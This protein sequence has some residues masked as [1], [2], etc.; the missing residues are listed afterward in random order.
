MTDTTDALDVQLR[1]LIPINGL[2]QHHQSEIISQSEIVAVKK[3]RFL[4]NRG[5]SDPYSFYVIDGQI[6][7]SVDGSRVKAVEGGTDGAKMAL[8]QLQPRQMS[9]KALTSVR[10]L[11]MDRGLLDRVLMLEESAIQGEMEVADI[12]GEESVDWMTRMLQSELFAR[13]PAANIQG[14][15]SRM[16]EIEAKQGEVIVK[17]GTPGDYYYVVQRGRCA[18]TRR[19]SSNANEI[20]LAE[21]AEGD[22]FGEE[23]LV[24][25]AK[26]NANV[27][28][29]TDGVLMRLTKE[30][31]VQLIKTPAL[32]TVT[33]DEALVRV[34]SGA[35]W[36]DVRFPDELG[37]LCVPGAMNIPLNVL[38]IQ[39]G[40]LDVAVNY[41]AVCDSGVRSSSAAFLLTGL[42]FDVAYL[43]GGLNGTPMA[44][45]PM[46]QA[47]TQPKRTPSAAP[48]SAPATT[49]QVTVPPSSGAGPA[50]ST[51][52]CVAPAAVKDATSPKAAA[53]ESRATTPKTPV[54]ASERVVSVAPER[55]PNPAHELVDAEVRASALSTELEKAK[56][57]LEAALQ[58]RAEAEA[59]ASANENQLNEAIR[60]ERERAGEA[61][62]AASAELRQAQQ[63]KLEAVEAKREAEEETRR[64]EVQRAA[65]ELAI[66]QERAR[67]DDEAKDKLEV[68]RAEDARRMDEVRAQEGARLDG[69][70]A[71]ALAAVER[72][73]VQVLELAERERTEVKRIE[74]EELAERERVERER[75][76]ALEAAERE[77]AQREQ[78][79]AQ[80]LAAREQADRERAEEVARLE[81]ARDE[82]LK[83]IRAESEQRVDEETNRRL[84][85][86]VAQKIAAEQ[87]RQQA[88]LVAEQRL[89]EMREQREEE[90]R[91]AE[92]ALKE[93]QRLKLEIESAKGAAE[94]EA[95]TLREAQALREQK[96]EADAERRLREN[97]AHLEK[98][99]ARNAEALAEA[100]ELRLAAEAKADE[101][102]MHIE[103]QATEAKERLDEAKKLSADAE[104]AKRQ[105]ERE[106]RRQLALRQKEEENLR[107]ALDQKLRE[108]RAKLERQWAQSAQQMEQIKRDKDAAEAA[109]VAAQEEAKRIIE[110]REG[111]YR[112][113]MARETARLDGERQ[114]MAEDARRV[115]EELAQARAAKEESELLRAEVQAQLDASTAQERDEQRERELQEKIRQV[116]ARVSQADSELQAAERAQ[117]QASVYQE[118]Q[119]AELKKKFEET[120]RLRRQLE[121]EATAWLEESGPSPG[122]R[123]GEESEDMRR[124]KERA[125]RV[126]SESDRAVITMLDDIASQMGDE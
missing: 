47:K 121:E 77:R 92:Q 31:F 62:R 46:P 87:A 21:L 43:H 113:K 9:A 94:R 88:E 96:I 52:A 119:D 93:A 82:E 54:S 59:R 117:V 33:Y 114:K 3:G 72:E 53:V 6:E 19:A 32:E 51:A 110:E 48:P 126:L 122:T 106:A 14:V 57:A 67:L 73:R 118:A 76:Q 12:D 35:V 16:E 91:R 25:G 22:S 70:R 85:E 68:A 1:A 66:A 86:A 112:Q 61:A 95:V 64:L 69:E 104:N 107:I 83:R 49:P 23:A 27:S 58:A 20:Q 124:I 39:S 101:A 109:R 89:L 97:E 4:F 26:R 8:A 37:E 65:A 84:E 78:A 50:A 99:Y 18:I 115:R 125:D 102:R 5:D 11:R 10:V 116:E 105:L 74:A 17:Q 56:H 120:E 90:T 81:R 13:I 2:A 41:V 75:A 80:E 71:L 34:R 44:E 38:R 100:I 111:E 40:Q 29:L 30:D 15:F 7:L 36:L 123:F 24:S 79:Q 98:E 103:Q 63:L 108:E 60:H 42:G 55:T 28:M 45:T